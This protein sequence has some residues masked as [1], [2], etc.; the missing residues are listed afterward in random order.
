MTR[1][2]HHGYWCTK[3]KKRHWLDTKIG[4]NH[5]QYVKDNKEQR[6]L[7]AYLKIEK[8]EK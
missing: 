2:L 8:L 7:N 3:C 5:I 6:T 4:R 1:Q